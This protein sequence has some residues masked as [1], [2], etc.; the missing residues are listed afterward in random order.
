MTVDDRK[1]VTLRWREVLPLY[2]ETNAFEGIP[3]NSDDAMV[4]GNRVR[5]CLVG[6]YTVTWS[7]TLNQ[8]ESW[9]NI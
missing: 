5:S 3:I 2:I 9:R 4:H 6:E 7:W 8:L 1:S